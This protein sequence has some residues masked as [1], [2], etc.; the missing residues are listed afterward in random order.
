MNAVYDHG[1]HGHH[2]NALLSRFPIESMFNHDVFDH[3][4]ESLGILHCVLHLGDIPVHC[5]VVHLGLF[6]GSRMRQTEALTHRKIVVID[7]RLAF[8]GGLNINDDLISDE[9]PA[10][11]D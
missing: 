9:D 6:S 4:F 8:L 5:Y 11:S 7:R 10:L 1:H 3:A 2:G